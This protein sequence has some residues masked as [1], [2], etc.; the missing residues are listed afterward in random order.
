MKIK[1]IIGIALIVLSIAGMVFWES[2]GREAVVSTD[3]LTAARDISE[4]ETVS[5]GDIAVSSVDRS[6]VMVSA[7]P[8]SELDTLTGMRLS[9]SVK[10]GQQLASD[11]FTDAPEFIEEGESIFVIPGSWIF[12]MSS[13]PQ[14]EDRCDFYLM[15]DESFIGSYVLAVNGESIEIVCTP[16]EYFRIFDLMN[17]EE[18]SSL[19]IV[20][21]EPEWRNLQ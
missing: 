18:L 3:I 14:R 10:E 5:E 9:S 2:Y 1:S 11:H 19:M 4:G 6:F 7:L 15:P 20:S 21:S 17:R 8:A 13:V 16:D 12:T